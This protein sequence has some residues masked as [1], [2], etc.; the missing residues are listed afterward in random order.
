MTC[1]VPP[2]YRSLLVDRFTQRTPVALLQCPV[3]K[4]ILCCAVAGCSIDHREANASITKFL[5][6]LIKT[7]SD[8][9][10]R[11]CIPLYSFTVLVDVPNS[12][13]FSK[14]AHYTP[15]IFVHTESH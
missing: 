11:A 10:V 6:E 13:A 5:S 12:C 9:K 14:K 4:P 7:A 15:D 8:K 1:A 2:F 3:M